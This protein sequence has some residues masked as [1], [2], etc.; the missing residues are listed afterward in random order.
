MIRDVTVAAGADALRG[1]L[2]DL[3]S[4]RNGVTAAGA[5]ITRASI[6]ILEL[7]GGR[8][9]RQACHRGPWCRARRH[10]P[11][12][13]RHLRKIAGSICCADVVFGNGGSNSRG[14][15][16]R[17]AVKDGG[18]VARGVAG[19]LPGICGE[20]CAL[21]LKIP[22]AGIRLLWLH[23]RAGW[24]RLPYR[25]GR[26]Y[27]R[28]RAQRR[29]AGTCR[30]SGHHGGDLHKRPDGSGDSSCASRQRTAR[31]ARYFSDGLRQ[32]QAGSIQ[33]PSTDVGPHLPRGDRAN[34]MRLPFRAGDSAGARFCDR[35]RAGLKSLHGT[36]SEFGS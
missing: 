3:D 27:S 1:S 24:R 11:P 6:T 13:H 10:R 31:A 12:I 23:G 34:H 35:P 15:G 16:G 18:S 32:H 33:R 21:Q 26:G 7:C 2:D 17:C 25:G 22:I 8:R 19:A 20:V 9:D 30:E 28:R 29:R 5:V 14:V 4:L 36:G